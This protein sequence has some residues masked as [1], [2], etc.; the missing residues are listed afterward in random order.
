MINVNGVDYYTT[1]EA[2]EILDMKYS[3]TAFL[4]R[5][6]RIQKYENKYI[7][8]PQELSKLKERQNQRLKKFHLNLKNFES[9]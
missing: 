9:I 5:K 2:A 4:L 8:S 3:S 7:I 6:N 1:V